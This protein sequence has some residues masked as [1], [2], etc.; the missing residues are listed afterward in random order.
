MNALLLPLGYPG[1]PQ[2]E[3]KDRINEAKEY[4]SNIGLAVKST[5]DIITLADCPGA[6]EESKAVDV[7]FCIL[8]VASWIEVPNA[9]NVI[10]G[11]G[12]DR[13]PLLLWSLDNIYDDKSKETISFGSIAASA[14]LRQ[15]FEEF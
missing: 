13:L 9:L 3:L 1:Y 7:D 2:A 6:V 10:S 14:V 4:L 8:L 15:A 11:A 12:L 5:R